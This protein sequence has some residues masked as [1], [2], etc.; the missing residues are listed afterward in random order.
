MDNVLLYNSIHLDR[1]SPEI[2]CSDLFGFSNISFPFYSEEDVL[3]SDDDG[4]EE[5]ET[6]EES[7][8]VVSDNEVDQVEDPEEESVSGNSVSSNESASGNEIQ[9]SVSDNE[10][11]SGNELHY[12][13]TYGDIVVNVD[14]HLEEYMPT[15]IDLLTV[16]GG[17]LLG[18]VVFEL[19]K[20]IYKFFRIFF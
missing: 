18:L 15:V 4:N 10:T 12:V 13:E 11:A 8:D 9:E 20:Y 19:L 17:L 3:I 2:D 14:S 16:I 6:D 7:E 5:E 1:L